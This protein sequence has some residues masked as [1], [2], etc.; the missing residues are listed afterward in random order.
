[1]I[2]FHTVTNA[3]GAPMAKPCFVCSGV[4]AT[5]IFGLASY[6]IPCCVSCAR[7][8]G[9]QAAESASM[10]DELDHTLQRI[11]RTRGDEPDRLPPKGAAR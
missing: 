2:G 1:M 10:F 5:G 4:T 9:E 3:E 11:E 7:S 6:P 8:I